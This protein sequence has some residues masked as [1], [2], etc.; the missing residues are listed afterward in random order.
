MYTIV[1]LNINRNT[2]LAF[3]HQQTA[4]I[5]QSR[6]YISCSRDWNLNRNLKWYSIAA[7]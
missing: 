1:L 7:I 4:L 6:K 3:Q 5:T 2:A